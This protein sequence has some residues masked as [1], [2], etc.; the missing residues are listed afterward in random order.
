MNNAA[1][2]INIQVASYSFEWI[3]RSETVETYDNSMLHFLKKY[4][5]FFTVAASFYI[6]TGN[7]QGFLFLTIL[8][9]ICFFFSI[10]VIAAL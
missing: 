4:H 2:N 6:P 3:T 5:S 8:T 7:T 1:V 9:K 10:V